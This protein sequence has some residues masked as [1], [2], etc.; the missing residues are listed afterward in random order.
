M[1]AIEAHALQKKYG[2]FVAVNGIDFE[3]QRGECFGFLG[4]NGA[5]KT[6]TMKMIYRASPVGGGTLS[7]LGWEA[8]SGQTQSILPSVDADAEEAVEEAA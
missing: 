3:V 1:I 7:I 5:G 2:D 8:G 6:T 4:P